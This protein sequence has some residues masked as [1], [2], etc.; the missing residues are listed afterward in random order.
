MVTNILQQSTRFAAKKQSN[1]LSAAA[2]ITLASVLSA[3]LGFYRERI[4]I[5]YFFATPDLQQQLDAYRVASRL[6]EFA[7]QLLVIG[8]LSASFIPVFSRYFKKNPSEAYD[9]SSSVMNL[10]LLFFTVFSVIVFIFTS[11]FTGLITSSNFTSQQVELAVTLT[12]IMLIAQFFFAVSNFLTGMVQSQ[13]RFLIPALAPIAH[14]LGIIVTIVLLAPHIGI[15]SAAVGI[16]VGAFFHLAFQ[17]PLA[18][19]LGF[20]YKF[21]IHLKHPGVREMIR[22]MPPRTLTIAIHQIEL[23]ATSFFTTAMVAGSVT[24][25]ELALRLMSA[26]I[27]VF[28]VPIGQ[29]SL[30]FLSNES[31]NDQRDQFKRTVTTTLHQIFYL[32]LPSSILILILRVPLVRIIYGAPEFPWVA[33]LITSRTVAVLSLSIF[34]QS[35]NHLLNRAFYALEDTRTP[36]YIALVAV[37]INIILATFFTFRT[38]FGV[39]GLAIAFSTSAVIHASLLLIALSRQVGGFPLKAILSQPVKM[40]IATAVTGVSLWIPMRLLDQFVFD[41]TLAIPLVLLTITATLVGFAVYI[42]MSKA[43]HIEAAYAYITILKKVGNWRK[44]LSQTDEVLETPS[45]TQEINP[46]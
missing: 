42:L 34:A 20:H 12:R 30:S 22:L 41:T 35:A 18:R 40:V 29:A 32:A 23:F 38:D 46:L 15:Y 24:I 8:A 39:I 6:P 5:S 2:I 4:L 25:F 7:F 10:V 31:E 36:L 43:L 28:S 3:A 37:T 16:V 26:P 33:T 17:V 19:K 44:T 11:Q 21:I 13:Q 27:R 9:V 1:I 45:Q 14:N